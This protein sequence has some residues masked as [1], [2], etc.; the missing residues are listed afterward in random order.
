MIVAVFSLLRND[1]I[2]LVDVD[3]AGLPRARR[4]RLV[5]SDDPTERADVV[6]VEDALAGAV[7]HV[8]EELPARLA[9]LLVD[10]P[11][12][13]HLH[14]IA[15]MNRRRRLDLRADERDLVVVVDVDLRADVRRLLVEDV[16]LQRLRLI[17]GGGFV[18]RASDARRA[19]TAGPTINKKP[20]MLRRMAPSER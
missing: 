15:G 14:V 7:H 13:G 20:R 17:H 19:C 18:L 12:H 6:D 3:L 10:L 1:E 5:V 9:D 11:V 16:R 4:E 8:R 2:L